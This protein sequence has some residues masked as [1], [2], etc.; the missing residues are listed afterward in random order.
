M[1]L[2]TLQSK[3][4]QVADVLRKRIVSGKVIPGAKLS[5]VRDLAE[6]FKV[7]TKIVIGALDLLEK[8]HLIAREAGRGVFVRS[9]SANS[10]IEVCLMA[11]NI[12][13][14]SDPYFN[15]LVR[16]SYPPYLQDGFNF[17]VRTV[18]FSRDAKI[19]HFAQELQKFDKMCHAN[20]FLLSA[21]AFDVA[22]I[23][24]C[25]KIKTPVIFIGDFSHGLDPDVSFNQITG[26]NAIFGQNYV[27]RL[28]EKEAAKELVLYI[29]SLEHY[30]CRM[31]CKGAMEVAEE[32]NI[33]LHT[34]EMPKGFSR[35]T[36]QQQNKVF[37][38]KT[39]EAGIANLQNILGFNGGLP[40]EFLQKQSKCGTA[41]QHIYSHTNSS[42]YIIN[43][44]DTIF[45][46][47]KRITENPNETNKII[48]KEN[49]ED[50]AI[51]KI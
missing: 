9:C 45:R 6:S 34:I 50:F 42:K 15:D 38:E 10:N 26:D 39:N 27:K 3:S 51:T 37:L 43:F 13:F 28:V 5:S 40:N 44:Y 35:L 30:F 22:K 41:C 24:A 8:E 29:P 11:W 21:P 7:S 32:L 31:L 33:K 19:G 36:P 1:Q 17:T 23:K 18:P 14:T 46:E 2:F 16:M 4:E 25:L 12:N 47:I 48:L 49:L 20:C